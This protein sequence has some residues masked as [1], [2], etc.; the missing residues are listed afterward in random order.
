MKP[1]S[2]LPTNAGF[3][4]HLLFNHED[5][6]NMFLRNFGL[7]PKYTGLLNNYSSTLDGGSRLLTASLNKP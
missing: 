2:L 6:G 5:G 7:S 4:L 3:L 1:L